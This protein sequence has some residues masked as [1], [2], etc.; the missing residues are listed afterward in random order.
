MV[1]DKRTGQKR[2]MTFEYKMM[3]YLIQPSSADI[4]KEAM[5]RADAA[6]C[7]LILSV[8]DDLVTDERDPVRSMKRLSQAMESIELDVPL[9][10]DKKWSKKSW[11]ELKPWKGK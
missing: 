8:H 1:L 6:G 11:G 4:T 7:E 5:L 9:L 3:N 10:V 2:L